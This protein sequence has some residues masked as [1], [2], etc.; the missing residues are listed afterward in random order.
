MT[1]WRAS[2]WHSF[3]T[4]C[5]HVF[6]LCSL[7]FAVQCRER[8]A[9]PVKA[10]VQAVASD[11]AGRLHQPIYV[12]H[13]VKSKKFGQIFWLNCVFCVLEEIISKI[14]LVDFRD[15]SG[16]ILVI[17][18]LEYKFHTCL[19]AKTKTWLH[20]FMARSFMIFVNSF[21]AIS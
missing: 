6:Y 9:E 14:F 15:S 5:S 2:L 11:C 3:G 20:S 19:F 13:C 17:K 8:A 21:R 12:L 7:I 4:S 18:V 1:D 16:I 10:V